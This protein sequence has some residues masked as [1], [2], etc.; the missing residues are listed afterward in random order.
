MLGLSLLLCECGHVAG[1]RWASAFFLVT[2]T[3]RLAGP[4]G[5]LVFQG[6]EVSR[7]C[8][9]AQVMLIPCPTSSCH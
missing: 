4:W 3:F 8:H 9:K 2:R 7:S 5:S 1:P 6:L